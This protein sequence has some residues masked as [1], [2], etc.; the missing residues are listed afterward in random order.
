MCR[1]GECHFD[2]GC[3]LKTH[4][5][6]RSPVPLQQLATLFIDPNGSINRSNTDSQRSQLGGAQGSKDCIV[7]LLAPLIDRLREY[8][9][10]QPL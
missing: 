7:L 2:G 10:R 9:L 4:Q 6:C 3:W 5:Y 1:F 8:Q